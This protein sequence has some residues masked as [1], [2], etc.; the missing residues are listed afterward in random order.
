MNLPQHNQMSQITPE[1]Q[2]VLINFIYCRADK[3]YYWKD[4]KTWV[5]QKDDMSVVKKLKYYHRFSV[6]DAQRAT[7]D[8]ET[9]Q[10][11]DFVGEIAGMKA[12]VRN[13]DGKGKMLILQ[14][15][16]LLTRESG[17]ETPFLNTYLTD[18]L[19]EEQSLYFRCWLKVAF[20]NIYSGTRRPLPVLAVVGPRDSGKSLLN[21]LIIKALGNRVADPYKF[22]VENS[23]FNHE[24]IGSEIL[25]LDDTPVPKDPK[26][27]ET[28]GQ[29]I[30]NHLFAP[31]VLWEAKG[32]NGL[33]VKPVQ[34]VI[35]SCND[36]N[37]KL[38]P[39]I[40]ED[41]ED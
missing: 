19:G 32:V 36:N 12:G 10:S 17:K 1:Q 39:Q 13:L 41:L 18:L 29:T 15:Y 21:T 30:K 37:A 8:I 16:K 4:G 3:N 6:E 9:K 14:G 5:K 7:C 25:M 24:I 28:F 27:R 35:I 23:N 40:G 31:A 22:L 20:E 38:I 11:V 26:A 34:V 2:A 33:T